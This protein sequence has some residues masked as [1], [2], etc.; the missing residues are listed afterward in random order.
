M[1]CA[2]VSILFIFIYKYIFKNWFAH[3]VKKDQEDC[4]SV[5]QQMHGRKKDGKKLRSGHVRKVCAT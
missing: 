1:G 2:P 3:L 4:V 5:N